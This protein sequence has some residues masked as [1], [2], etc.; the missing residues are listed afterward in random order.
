MAPAVRGVDHG[1]V[2]ALTLVEWAQTAHRQKK[3][4]WPLTPNVSP[5]RVQCDKFLCFVF[6]AKALKKKQGLSGCGKKVPP[7]S[8]TFVSI[9]TGLHSHAKPTGIWSTNSYLKYKFLPA[10][11]ISNILEMGSDSD[12][13]Q[14]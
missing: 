13:S 5:G 8:Q 6:L 14:K 4:P 1:S 10:D 3:E 11:G 2:N 9:Q 7:N 12:S